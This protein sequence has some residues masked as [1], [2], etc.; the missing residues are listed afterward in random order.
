MFNGSKGVSGAAPVIQD[1]VKARRFSLT[2]SSGV[3]RAAMTIGSDGSPGIIL[4]DSKGQ[5]RAVLT[6]W[7]DGAPGL[8]LADSKGKRRAVMGLMED[9]APSV[10]L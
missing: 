5:A 1:V 10:T 2:D 4:I 7:E 8:V 3:E 6:L 9:G